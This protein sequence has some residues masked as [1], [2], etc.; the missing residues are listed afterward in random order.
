MRELISLKRSMDALDELYRREHELA[1]AYR[2]LLKACERSTELLADDERGRSLTKALLH[3]RERAVGGGGPTPG[4]PESGIDKAYL[5]WVEVLAE[6]LHAKEH[7]YKRIVLM[8]TEAALNCSATG[9]RRS[10]ELRGFAE[11]L[12]SAS[13][14][15]DIVAVRNELSRNVKALRATASELEAEAQA[16]AAQLQNQLAAIQE[17]LQRAEEAAST[18]PLTGLG[19]RRRAQVAVCEAISAHDKVSILEIDLDGFKQINDSCGHNQG[20]ELLKL[21]ADDLR[22]CVGANDTVCR[23]GGDEFLVVLPGCGLEA[24]RK[25]ADRIEAETHGP[26]L[27]GQKGAR[28]RV[29]L[30]GSLGIAE[31]QPGET[32]EDF[33]DRADR[34]MYERKRECQ[35][36]RIAS[37]APG[38]APSPV[39]ELTFGL[40]RKPARLRHVGQ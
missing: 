35:A 23:W 2:D 19:N 30:S 34:S 40:F 39:R 33:F 11:R 32:P 18:D 29:M 5:A 13:R 7:E 24:A 26:V 16:Q 15:P 3:A 27:L 21:F 10:G 12:E 37:A 20:D 17:R 4:P 31:Y 8:V 22:K 1:A 36:A 14:L 28:F 38:T 6:N 25:L 9:A